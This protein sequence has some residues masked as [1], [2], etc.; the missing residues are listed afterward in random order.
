LNWFS[1]AREVAE[2]SIWLD[3]L[4]QQI[5]PDQTANRAASNEVNSRRATLQVTVLPSTRSLLGAPSRPAS[6]LAHR[7][8]TALV[9]AYDST[10]IRCQS[11]AECANGKTACAIGGT[12]GGGSVSMMG[13]ERSL[14][15]VR[16]AIPRET[17]KGKNLTHEH[18]MI[19]I[20][21]VNPQISAPLPSTS[22]APFKH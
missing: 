6:T 20:Y 11:P 3:D 8:R 17:K 2:Y 16:L 7:V 22:H 18:R 15:V 21:H 12:C 5:G 4:L 1:V 9:E 13:R 10:S 14:N 19:C